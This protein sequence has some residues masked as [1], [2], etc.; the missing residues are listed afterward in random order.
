MKR[1]LSL[2]L[3]LAFSSALA[4]SAEEVTL[5]S[6]FENLSKKEQE[7]TAKLEANQKAR[8]AQR[9]EAEKKQAEQKAAL[10]KRQAE[11]QKAIEAKQEEWKK[12]QEAQ[13]A[14]LEKAK[15]RRRS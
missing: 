4:V 15:K 3:V 7:F 6:F 8:E 12:Q 13:K 1:V 9:I 14:A 11:Q 10:E 5:G 2:L